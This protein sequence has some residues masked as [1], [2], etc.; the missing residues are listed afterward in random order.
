MQPLLLLLLK[1][2]RDG[3]RRFNERK[4]SIDSSTDAVKKLIGADLNHLISVRTS[5]CRR[6]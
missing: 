2:L 1:P 3:I 4:E 5:D 6:T